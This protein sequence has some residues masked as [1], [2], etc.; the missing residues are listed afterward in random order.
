MLPITF[1]KRLWRQYDVPIICGNINE[2]IAQLETID[3]HGKLSTRTNKFGAHCRTPVSGWKRHWR[4]HLL[5][6]YHPKTQWMASNNRWLKH[7]QT[8]TYY[9]GLVPQRTYL[10]ALSVHTIGNSYWGNHQISLIKSS[11]PIIGI[12]FRLFSQNRKVLTTSILWNP[13]SSDI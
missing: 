2:S 5:H 7:K 9:F 3:L 13:T 1:L 12:M 4:P 8:A 6:I 10:E 11:E